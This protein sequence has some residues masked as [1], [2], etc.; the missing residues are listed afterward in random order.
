MA[1][2]LH[3]IRNVL[4][5]KE[6][7]QHFNQALD[8]EIPISALEPW[9]FYTIETQTDL[10]DASGNVSSKFDFQ[11]NN[12]K[13]F[14]NPLHPDR[15]TVNVRDLYLFFA[16]I[17]SKHI[18][19]GKGSKEFL[20]NNSTPDYAL[21][22][23]LNLHDENNK[24]I[25][26]IN[27]PSRDPHMAFQEFAKPIK[28]GE[29]KSL[30]QEYFKHFA[31]KT[32]D[33]VINQSREIMSKFEE[34]LHPAIECVFQFQA[35]LKIIS[36]ALPND[37]DV[38]KFG[39]M[40]WVRLNQYF[41]SMFSLFHEMLY[42]S[43]LLTGFLGA[44]FAIMLTLNSN[45]HISGLLF[46]ILL[47]TSTAFLCRHALTLPINKTS[48]LCSIPFSQDWESIIRSLDVEK[49]MQLS[50][51]W[52]NNR[53]KLRS[54]ESLHKFYVMRIMHYFIVL[55][56]VSKKNMSKE[57][58]LSGFEKESHIKMMAF[59]L[60]N[61]GTIV[62]ISVPEL[63]LIDQFRKT[64]SLDKAKSTKLGIIYLVNIAAGYTNLKNNQELQQQ[65]IHYAPYLATKN[66]SSASTLNFGFQ[67][68]HNILNILQNDGF[69]EYIFSN[70]NT[71]I[72]DAFLELK[73][74]SNLSSRQIKRRV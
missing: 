65:Q 11:G 52:A 21:P 6:E 41:S 57:G 2:L 9:T 29:I 4:T 8:R 67:A 28:F 60:E 45:E 24:P 59:L 70:F 55:W 36:P 51:H 30:F 62:E 37:E 56:L 64:T 73:S 3:E 26:I 10:F 54:L 13:I 69:I 5:Y 50:S 27:N 39:T 17:L 63:T 61:V 15:P 72:Q 42:D 18:S 25:D 43:N 34:A 49:M 68:L 33:D 12:F 20:I 14:V 38:L 1:E 16:D 48:A 40:L 71:L 58:N 44:I 22:L 46:F 7:N 32:S 74:L 31:A 47:N 19:F 66:F 35:S 53:P 23:I